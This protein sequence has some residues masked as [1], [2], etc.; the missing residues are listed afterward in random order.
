MTEEFSVADAAKYLGLTTEAVHKAVR[1]NR[2]DA[3][4]GTDPVRLSLR[5]V[6]DFHQ[7][8]RTSLVASLARRGETPVSTARK[9]RAA[10][11][12]NEM[13]LPRSFS[14]KLAAMPVDWRSLFSRAELAAACVTEGCRWCRAGEFAAFLGARPVEYAEAYVELFGS[15][16]CERCRPGL[17]RPFWEAMRARVHGGAARPS[18]ARV[19]P[20]VA[21]RE[22]AR[23]WVS[24]RAVTAA[25]SPVQDDD[26]RALVGRRLREERARLKAAKRAGDQRLVLQLARTVRALEADAARVDGRV[27]A[28]AVRPGRLACGHLLAAG[29]ACPRRASKRGQ[30]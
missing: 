1:E 20:S 12:H 7:L 6:E 17:L 8:R 28:A 18:A 10:L 16:P 15:Q 26:G 14:A 3:L 2:L 22:A 9:V 11:H 29:C 25:A 13:G 21:E 19:A 24:Q 23:A 27:P 5:A 4:P 30:R